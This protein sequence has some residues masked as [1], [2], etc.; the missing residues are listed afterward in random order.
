MYERK[1]PL[2]IDCGLHLTREV[3]NG[4][5]KPALLNAISMDIKRPS[6]MLRLLPGAT[7]RVLNVQLKELEEHG[8]IEKKIYSEV[9]PKVE[10][11]LTEIGWSLMPIIDAMNQWGDT[12]RSYLETVITQAPKIGEVSKSVCQGYREMFARGETR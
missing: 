11:S 4:K 6:E 5:W 8:M 10:Y 9:P 7:R 1:T 3:L 12:H 2:A